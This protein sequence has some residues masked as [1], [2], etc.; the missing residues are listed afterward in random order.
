MAH[1]PN[2]SD[3]IATRLAHYYT[4]MSTRRAVKQPV[5]LPKYPTEERFADILKKA[6]KQWALEHHPDKRRG[7]RAQENGISDQDYVSTRAAIRFFSEDPDNLSALVAMHKRKPNW[8][9]H[10]ERLALFGDLFD[11]GEV[12][13]EE[14]ND[15]VNSS[16]LA[17]D[18]QPHEHIALKDHLY[19]LNNPQAKALRSLITQKNMNEFKYDGPRKVARSASSPSRGRSG[20]LI[21]NYPHASVKSVGKNGRPKPNSEPYVSLPGRS[22]KK[23]Y[24]VKSPKKFYAVKSPKKVYA[25]KSP[26]KVYA[27]KSPSGRRAPSHEVNVVIRRKQ[28]AALSIKAAARSNREAPSPKRQSQ[29]ASHKKSSK[30]KAPTV[31]VKVSVAQKCKICGAHT[32][33]KTSCRRKSSCRLGCRKRCHQHASKHVTG[34]RCIDRLRVHAMV[35]K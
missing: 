19:G 27:V 8:K 22:P 13:W 23:V 18:K 31:S 14:Y 7:R 28:Q 35:R 26:K 1:V 11:Q 3:P 5:P 21:A 33:R 25:V 15:L 17:M 20:L 4:W 9:G 16:L 12:D 2:K 34:K 30:K 10:R 6:D 24:A 29:K 32:K